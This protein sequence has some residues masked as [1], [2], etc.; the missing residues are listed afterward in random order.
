MR[1]VVQNCQELINLDLSFCYNITDE[2]IVFLGENSKKVQ[3][4]NLESCRRLTD[5]SFKYN[6]TKYQIF[7]DFL[8]H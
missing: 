7:N 3:V 6:N 5:K 4:L 2:G 8:D 1:A